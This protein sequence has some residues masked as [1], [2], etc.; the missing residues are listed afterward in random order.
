MYSDEILKKLS[1]P[2]D[3]AVFFVSF[4]IGFVLDVLYFGEGTPSGTVAGVLAVGC[5]GIKK[6]I[7]TSLLG[8]TY[9]ANKRA[10]KRAGVIRRHFSLKDNQEACETVRILEKILEARLI[11]SEQF[12]FLI[13]EKIQSYVNEEL[14]MVGLFRGTHQKEMKDRNTAYEK[15]YGHLDKLYSLSKGSD[16]G[17]EEIAAFLQKL[18]ATYAFTEGEVRERATKE[19]AEAYEGGHLATQPENM[20]IY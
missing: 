9:I 19:E 1:E 13:D 2:A 18:D 5:L 17:N 20:Q 16:Q 4:A 10:R 15:V 11:D 8:S 6:A 14:M 12:N 7:E 3:L